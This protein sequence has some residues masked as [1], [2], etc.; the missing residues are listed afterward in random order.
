MQRT[1]LNA[2]IHRATVTKADLDYEGSVTIDQS[3]MES[4]NIQAYEAVHIW[5]VTNG[6]RIQTYAIPG[7][8]GSGEIQIN[9][10]AAHLVQAGHVVVIASFVTL[11]ADEA[12]SHKPRKV[13]VDGA[14]RI[15]ETVIG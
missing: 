11:T 10:G 14:N 13:F 1:Y 5:D 6:Q 4:A 12:K 2:K 15:T 7:L 9:G 3:L 8:P